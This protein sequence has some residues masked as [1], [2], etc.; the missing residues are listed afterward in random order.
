MVALVRMMSFDLMMRAW[1]HIVLSLS[2]SVLLL[3]SVI[4]TR[5]LHF[6]S[7]ISMHALVGD[8]LFILL[9]R[10]NG[11]GIMSTVCVPSGLQIKTADGYCIPLYMENGLSCIKLQPLYSKEMATLPHVILTQP[12]GD[13][14]WDPI[15]L[16]FDPVAADPPWFNALEHLEQHPYA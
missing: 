16:D 13:K 4:L 6:S 5:D 8:P 10:L 9:G 15:V 11:L 3:A 2:S 12:E 7:C 14:A 1:I